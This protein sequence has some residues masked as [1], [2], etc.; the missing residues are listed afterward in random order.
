MTPERWQQVDKVLQQVLAIDPAERS[1]VLAEL[2]SDDPGLRKEVES[3]MS[4]QELAQNFLAIPAVEENSYL[5]DED[6]GESMVG[7]TMGRYIIEAL[8]GAGGMGEVYLAHDT[9]LDQKVAIKFLSSYLQPNIRAKERLV[10]EAKALAQLD[11][12]NICRV[13][14]IKDEGTR[15]FIVMQFVAGETLADRLKKNPLNIQQTLAIVIQVLEALSEAHSVGIV[16]RDI[17]PRNIMLNPR[18]QVKV[19]DFGLVKLVGSVSEEQDFGGGASLLSRTGDFSGTP[20]YMSPEQASAAPVDARSDLFA[21]GVI[22]YECVTGTRPFAGETDEKILR[23]V[24]QFHPA[25]P[26]QL[27]PLVGPELD[28]VIVK[29]LAKNRNAR[30]QSANELLIDLRRIQKDAQVEDDKETKPL[31]LTSDAKT[32]SNLTRL[33]ATLQRPVL[34]LASIFL[35]IAILMLVIQWY[36]TDKAPSA[37]AVRWYEQGIAALREGTYQKASKALEQAIQA[38]E[39]FALAHARLAEAYAELDYTD[40]AKDEIIRAESLANYSSME[41]RDKLYL[42]AIT[43]TVLRDFATAIQNYQLLL[44]EPRSDKA[45]VYADLARAY[46]KNDQLNEAKVNYELAIK[47]DP[48]DAAALLRRGIVCGQQQDFACAGEM[49]QKAESVYAAQSNF[50]GVTEVFYERGFLALNSED[51]EAARAAL[52]TALQRS[53]V[54]KNHYQQIKT[55]QALSAVAAMQGQT[56]L[57]EQQAT[58]AIALARTEGSENQFTAGLI[59]L[60][61]AFLMA[62]DFDRAEKYY[63]QALN[64]AQREKLRLREAWARLQLGSLRLS[65][66]KTREALTYLEAAVPFYRQSGYRKWL[67]QILTLYGRALRNTG[68]YEAALKT[69]NELLTVAEQLGDGVQVATSHEEIG[70]VLLVQER[71]GEALSRFDESCKSYTS[72]K[73]TLYAGFC[74]AHSAS[75]LWRMGR[76]LE[77]RTKLREASSIAAKAQNKTLMAS[78]RLTEAM[79]EFSEQN[80]RQAGVLAEEVMKLAGTQF[81]LTITQAKYLSCLTQ[82][83]SGAGRAGRKSCEAAVGM[84]FQTDDHYLISAAQLAQAEVGLAGGDA[85]KSLQLALQAQRNFARMG[86]MDSEWR[87]WL[88]AARAGRQLGNKAATREFAEHANARLVSLEQRWGKE[89]YDGYLSRKDV[90]YSRKQ[91]EQLLNP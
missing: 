10:L 43:R 20:P 80:Y 9:K 58:E 76:Y 67:S 63:Q 24:R 66:H 35:V 31:P 90:Q 36:R 19:L 4:F 79:L 88:I 55:L 15:S 1:A 50:E 14:D 38:D 46:E 34:S 65:Q 87:A 21:V 77:A 56:Q 52:E 22:L 69:F 71:Y 84:A 28:S 81:G 49:F 51:V 11:H 74:E 78:V 53:R 82:M 85:Q 61:N 25:P 5:L 60:G 75:V 27:N 40:K 57:A 72:M 68:D 17:K 2:C 45:H 42:Q 83:Y 44:E 86:Q 89:V 54:S 91:L 8:L 3:L 62:G 33:T 41:S 23:R 6:Q 70:S 48:Q 39:N 16:H 18:G 73:L 47:L 29:A 64:L 32:H 59:W 12:P 30:Y 13:I 26:S 7:Q 37:E